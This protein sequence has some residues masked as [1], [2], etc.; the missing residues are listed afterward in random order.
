MSHSLIVYLDIPPC[1]GAFTEI[2]I[3]FSKRLLGFC[4]WKKKSLCFADI[5]ANIIW[6]S[7]SIRKCSPAFMTKKSDSIFCIFIKH[8]LSWQVFLC[9]TFPTDLP[10]NNDAPLRVSTLEEECLVIRSDH[11]TSALKHVNAIRTGD[12]CIESVPS[13]WNIL[14]VIDSH[15]DMSDY[16]DV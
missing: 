12:E 16:I 1:K 11:N 13:A 7:F 4:M 3:T 15:M 8:C 2:H 5:K 9:P 10:W 14:A 6:F